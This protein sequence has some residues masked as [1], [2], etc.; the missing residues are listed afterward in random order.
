MVDSNSNSHGV[1]SGPPEFGRS[2]HAGDLTPFLRRLL[3]GGTLSREAS[4][5]AFEGIMSG[6]AHQA[7]IGSLLTLLAIREPTVEELVGAATVMRE[8]VDRLETGI[9]AGRLLDTAGTGGAPKTFN[10]STAAA[11]VAAYTEATT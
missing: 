3:A 9:D 5:S 8:K 11:I 4:R 6:T 10:V 2:E 7:E 1:E